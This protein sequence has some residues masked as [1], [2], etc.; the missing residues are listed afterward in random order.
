MVGMQKI[1]RLISQTRLEGKPIPHD[2]NPAVIFNLA[3]QEKIVNRYKKDIFFC[4]Y[5]TIVEENKSAIMMVYTMKLPGPPSGSSAS[6]EI[7]MEVV[8]DMEK[9]LTPIYDINFTRDI[10]GHRNVAFIKFIILDTDEHMV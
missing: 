2:M 3:E 5:K 4:V 1:Q 9:F 10:E 7:V 8:G 6:S